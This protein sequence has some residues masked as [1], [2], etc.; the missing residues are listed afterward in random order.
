MRYAIIDNSTLTAV[1]RLLGDIPIKNKYSIDGDIL[2]FESFIQTVLFYDDVFFVD[3]YKR[4]YRN[5]R[6]ELFKYIYPIELEDENYKLLMNE[7]K[8]ITNNYVTTIA[9][10]QFA[11][12]NFKE[13]FEMLRM[14]ITFTWDL[15]SSVYYL[16]YKLLQE[17][18]GVDIGKYSE[19]SSMIYDQLMDKTIDY[20]TPKAKIYD[21]WGREINSSYTV[22]NSE[23]REYETGGMTKQMQVFLSGL[24]WLDFR[25]TFYNLVANQCQFDLVLHPI[26]NAY[27]IN[28]LNRLSGYKS[29][30]INTIIKAMNGIVDKTLNRIISAAQPITI[31]KELPMFSVWMADKYENIADFIDIVYHLKG[32]K[33]F[34]ICREILSDLDDLYCNNKQADYIRNVNLLIHDLEKQMKRIEDLYGVNPSTFSPVSSLIWTNNVAAEIT[35]LP[36]L[37]EIKNR[38][39]VPTSIK[40]L[41]RYS[42]FGATYKSLI[43]DLVQI[44]GLGA[45]HD[46]ITKHVVVDKDSRYFDIKTEE[47][48]FQN[49][50][51]WFKIPM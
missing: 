6:Q 30:C 28:L 27:S 19:L 17:H 50:K 2:A 3:D 35:N 41:R 40:K 31:E 37:P 32:E 8:K 36:T 25:T 24:S 14:N 15:S 43:D 20:E 10:R 51:T 12:D 48:R 22:V 9:K 47:Q 21:S 13:F 42:G 7:T 45:Y 1:Q 34:T 16:N 11:N 44:Q 38:I 49:Y 33:E 26:R 4:Q 18:S 39:T 29:T 5:K 23:G 46:I